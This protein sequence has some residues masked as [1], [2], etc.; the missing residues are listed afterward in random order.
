MIPHHQQQYQKYLNERE[1]ISWKKD[2]KK[3]WKKL[4][5][6]KI[7]NFY[8]TDTTRWIC[9]CLSFTR[10]RF[11]LCKHLVQ[12]YGRPESFHNICR[13]EKYPFIIF[14]TKGNI[15]ELNVGLEN[16]KIQKGT[17]TVILYINN[18]FIHFIHLIKLYFLIIGILQDITNIEDKDEDETDQLFNEYE[19]WLSGTLEI[20]RKQ[21][22]LG[23][24]KWAKAVR[25]SLEGVHKLYIDV[26]TYQNRVTNPRTWKDHNKHTMFLE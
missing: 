10:N 4:E 26:K 6:V 11:F 12:Q 20:V 18:K 16:N 13:Q 3:E 8:L 7:N 14:N 22:I 1:Y 9:G 24:Y 17:Y 2:F 19:E 25:N 15:N 21:R 23:N 5:N